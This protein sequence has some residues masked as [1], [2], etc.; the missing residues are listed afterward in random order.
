MRVQGH[1]D[2]LLDVDAGQV[3]R[4]IANLTRMRFCGSQ[5][6]A[7]KLAELRY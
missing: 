5:V 1:L 4:L 3:T 6:M 7:G 2:L